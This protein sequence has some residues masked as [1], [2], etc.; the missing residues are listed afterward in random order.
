MKRTSDAV[1][2]LLTRTTIS[3][4]DKIEVSLTQHKF[5]I[6]MYSRSTILRC[7]PSL[8]VPYYCSL[9]NFPSNYCNVTFIL[10]PTDSSR[11]I[12]PW[13]TRWVGSIF[14]N[15]YRHLPIVLTLE[16]D[17]SSPIIPNPFVLSRQIFSTVITYLIILFQFQM[18]NARNSS[19]L[20]APNNNLQLGTPNVTNEVKSSWDQESE[21]TKGKK[22]CKFAWSARWWVLDWVINAS[23]S[24]TFK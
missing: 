18:S 8:L 11:W 20:G 16:G 4:E 13:C 7:V 2:K 15:R 22:N 24:T 1:H 23:L 12:V 5:V 6:F 17:V 21:E 3:S 10:P 9:K 14:N 19:Y